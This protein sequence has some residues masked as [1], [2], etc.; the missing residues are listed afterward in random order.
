MHRIFITGGAGFI[1]YTLN[2][3]LLQVGYGICVYDNLFNGRV[4]NVPIQDGAMFVKGDILDGALLNKK[5]FDFSPDVVIHLAALHFIPYCNSNPLET[6]KVNI[7]GTQLV[8]DAS[9][10][11]SVRK[12]LFASSAAVYPISDS[13][14][15]E[16]VITE[17]MDIYGVSKVA[18]EHIIRIASKGSGIPMVSMRFFNAYGPRETNP[19]LIPSLVR[20]LKQG[21]RKVELGN[22]EPK[23]DF[24]HTDDLTD[25]IIALIEA[26]F[27]GY[28]VFNLG[29]GTE[30]SVLEIVGYLQEALGDEIEVVSKEELQRKAERMHLLSDISRIK[31]ATNWHPRKDIKDGLKELLLER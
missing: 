12:V 1:G 4:E 7:E 29:N 25:A 26:D 23:R 8:I 14:L 10:K 18:G 15:S 11:S 31:K 24:I 19:H 9:L 22:L 6:I 21:V 28:E 17:P 13:A 5:L 30:H 20:Q 3:K 16:D 2:K 27:N